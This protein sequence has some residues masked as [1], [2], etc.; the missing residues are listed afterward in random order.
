MPAKQILQVKVIVI[1]V[2]VRHKGKYQLCVCRVSNMSWIIARSCSLQLSLIRKLQSQYS[3]GITLCCTCY[4]QAEQCFT[5]TNM[6][7]L[8]AIHLPVIYEN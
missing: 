2:A 5:D 4:I 3:P 1:Y 7:C 6:S 8:V